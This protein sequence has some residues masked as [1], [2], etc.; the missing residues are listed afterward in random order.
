VVLIA[1][2]HRQIGTH[3]APPGQPPLANLDAGSLDMLRA[4]FNRA[5]GEA[6][7]IVLLAPT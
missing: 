3:N 1:L 4:D 5:A 2:A 6:R 7:I